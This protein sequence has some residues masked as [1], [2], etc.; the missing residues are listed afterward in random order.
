MEHLP[1]CMFC[2]YVSD[3]YVSMY[4]MPYIYKQLDFMIFVVLSNLSNSMIYEYKHFGT[5]A[6]QKTDT[7]VRVK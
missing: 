7:S 3:M 5:A 1:L 2:I 4:K 6:F